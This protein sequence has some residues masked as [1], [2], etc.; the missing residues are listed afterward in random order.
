VYDGAPILAVLCDS[1]LTTLPRELST[2]GGCASG[3]PEFTKRALAGTPNIPFE[4]PED[5]SFVDID[6]DTGKLAVPGC[7]RVIREAFLAGTE[8]TQACDLH[9]F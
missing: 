9:R 4:V 6:P 2:R 1:S 8:P 5:V 3:L 7:P